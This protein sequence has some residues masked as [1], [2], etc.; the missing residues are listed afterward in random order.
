MNPAA[1]FMLGAI[2]MTV[3]VLLTYV[4]FGDDGE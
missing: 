3:I 2:T 1:F 4:M